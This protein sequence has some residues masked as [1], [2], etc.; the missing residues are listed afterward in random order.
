MVLAPLLLV[1]WR[2]RRSIAALTA[3]AATALAFAG[4]TLALAG[5]NGIVQVLTF[6]GATGWHVESLAGSLV[7]LRDSQTLRLESGAWRIGR[8]N[9]LASIAMF[10]AAAPLCVWSSWRGAVTGRVGAGWLA[11]VSALLLLSA[12]FSAQYVIWLA[13]AG[14]IAWVSGEK[15]LA[16][17]TLLAIV[18]TQI[19]WMSYGGV[20]H[21]D[22][23][24]MLVVVA[25]N[26]VII[27]LAACAIARLAM[28]AG[29]AAL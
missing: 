5:A 22:L 14:A 15:R 18:L 17:L 12:L 9:R 24:A 28:P 29:G 19:L 25:R 27:V 16:M 3:F 21:S 2:E 13:P 8:I 1:P 10:L 11:S 4:L 20:M 26:I 23:A 6:R 7:H